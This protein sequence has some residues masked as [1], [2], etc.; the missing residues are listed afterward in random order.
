MFV[1]QIAQLN[2]ADR[3]NTLGKPFIYETA[4]EAHDVIKEELEIQLPDRKFRV[5]TAESLGIAEQAA[6]VL[7]TADKET[8]Q[9]L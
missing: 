3:W 2:R 8:G 9:Y 5:V 6:V 4:N 1:V 7:A